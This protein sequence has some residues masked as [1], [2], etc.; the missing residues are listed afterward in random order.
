VWLAKSERESTRRCGTAREE[1]RKR[2]GAKRMLGHVHKQR[3]AL[4][5]LVGTEVDNRA[6]G[7]LELGERLRAAGRDGTTMRVCRR[8][9]SLL[10]HHSGLRV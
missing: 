8:M 3:I 1:R 4:Q 6:I 9:P 7:A 10:S 2:C 5:R